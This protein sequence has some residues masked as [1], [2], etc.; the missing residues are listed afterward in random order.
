M[1]FLT[2]DTN[3]YRELGVSF[4]KNIHFDYLSKFLEKSHY[5]LILSNIVYKELID[6]FQNDYLKKITYDYQEIYNRFDN[7]DYL[8]NINNIDTDLLEKDALNKFIK[9]LESTCWKIHSLNYIDSDLLLEFL[10]F[11]KRE[12]KKDNTRDFLI[13]LG[14]IKLAKQNPDDKVIFITRDR[15]F[16]ENHFLQNLISKEKLKNI[17]V[18]ESIPKYL[19]DYGLQIDFLT[20]SI[21][22]NSIT[23]M[24]IKKEVLKDI[25][26]FPSYVSNYYNRIK[27]PENS[28]FEI[29]EIKVY[30]YYTFSENKSKITLI[31]SFLVKIKSIYEKET[32][33]DLNDYPKE[34]FYEQIEHRIDGQNRPIYENYIL[35]MFEGEIDLK[36]KKIK[37]QKFLDFIPDWNVEKK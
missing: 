9:K 35:C 11:S 36:I 30:D 33:V 24:E 19:S 21:V 12:S 3:I 22:L 5:E 18:I 6:Y 17:I 32:R 20:D 26:C 29:L 2:F 34:Y 13:W 8:E 37:K 16:T 28:S 31:S 10:I 15:I 27:P 7:S 23:E 4:N 14:L 25:E 1:H